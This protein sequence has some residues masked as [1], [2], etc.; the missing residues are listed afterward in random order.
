MMQWQMQDDD[1]WP[2]NQICVMY[3]YIMLVILQQNF[4]SG[5][6]PRFT[7]VVCSI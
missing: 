3:Y 1:A 6:K 2:W 7:E 5:T 4:I